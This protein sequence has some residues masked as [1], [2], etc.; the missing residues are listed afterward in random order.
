MPTASINGTS[1]DNSYAFDQPVAPFNEVKTRFDETLAMANDMMDLLV[2]ADGAGGYLGDLNAVISSA[3]VTSVT[4]PFVDTSYI[5]ATSGQE[6][7]VFDRS[8]LQDYPAMPIYPDP[9]ILP[10]PAVDT[11][12]ED[13]DEPADVSPTLTYAEVQATTDVY[14]PLVARMLEY[15]QAGYTGIDPVAEQAIYDRAQTRQQTTRL[16]EWNK[17][18]DLNSSLQFALPSGVLT[19]ALTDFGIG[20]TR[21]DADINNQIIITQ[22]ELE[23]KNNQFIMQQAIA[24]EQLIR[25]TTSE[26]SARALDAAKAQVSAILQ[27]FSERVKRYVSIWEGRKIMV[28]AQVESLRGVIEANKGAVDVFKAQYEALKTRVEAVTAQNKG[29]TD[30]FL[31]EVQGF[32]EAERA[33][34]A[35]NDSAVKLIEAKVAAADLEVRSEIA[36]AQSLLSGY[37]YEGSLRERVTSNMAQIAAQAV[38]SM[39]SAVTASASWGY[40]ASESSSTSFQMGTSLNESHSYEHDPSA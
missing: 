2:G 14:T 39:M 34:S 15:L 35:R 27:D 33:V 21:Q 38:A 9:S 5:L 3:P 6:V 29:L 36:N 25:Q 4:A 19:S 31:G 12:F 17:I 7:P 30:T 16:A 23:Q 37:Q 13:I 18:N 11:S 8:D 20:A 1:I 10:L 40:S 26:Q 28:Q 32:G 22:T 24:F